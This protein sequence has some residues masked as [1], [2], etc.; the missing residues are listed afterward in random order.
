MCGIFGI[1]SEKDIE[2]N[3]VDMY[4]YQKMEDASPNRFSLESKEN[5]PEKFMWRVEKTQLADNRI[6]PMNSLIILTKKHN[7]F[8]RDGNHMIYKKSGSNV[9]LPR[10]IYVMGNKHTVKSLLKFMDSNRYYDP[11]KFNRDNSKPKVRRAII[12]NN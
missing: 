7:I 4:I 1:T 8:V 3:D 12:N 6:L 11:I 9:V 2:A 5:Q 10:G